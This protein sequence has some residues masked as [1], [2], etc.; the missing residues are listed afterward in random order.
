M[1]KRVTR[2]SSG[3]QKRQVRLLQKRF[4]NEGMSDDEARTRA[5]QKSVRLGRGGAGQGGRIISKKAEAAEL[6]RRPKRTRG[7]SI[8][9]GKVTMP[10]RITSKGVDAVNSGQT[11]R[12]RTA[13][14]SGKM[15]VKK[16]SK[17]RK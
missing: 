3:R 14:A 9:D 8:K 7:I 1:L 17:R 13:L 4:K 15:L 11:L 16:S 6:A 5:N 10:K 2:G 12:K